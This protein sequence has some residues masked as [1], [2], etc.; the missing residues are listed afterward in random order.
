MDGLAPA[1]EQDRE[2]K[3]TTLEAVLGVDELLDTLAVRSATS[4]TEQEVLVHQ[5]TRVLHSQQPDYAVHLRGALFTDTSATSSRG[6]NMSAALKG[7]I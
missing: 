4:L 3:K 6:K 2:K 5:G 1:K 7:M